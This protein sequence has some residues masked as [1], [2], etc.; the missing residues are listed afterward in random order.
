MFK[1]EP[2]PPSAKLFCFGIN[3]VCRLITDYV[4]RGR[5]GAALYCQQT[6]GFVAAWEEEVL[7]FITT[8]VNNDML[9]YTAIYSQ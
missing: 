4:F 9:E 7:V 3:P 6:Q 8:R 1:S 2:E 5:G